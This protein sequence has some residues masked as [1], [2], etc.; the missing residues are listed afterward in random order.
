MLDLRKLKD[1]DLDPSQQQ[2][3][4]VWKL[5]PTKGEEKPGPIAHHTSVVVGDKMYLFGGSNLETEN[6]KF[7]SLE[8]NQFK[9]ETIK[10]RG[11][12]P[13]TRDEHTAVIFEGENSMIVYGGFIKGER[14]N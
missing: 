9:W 4:C 13:E 14:T 6:K 10:V 1:M 12:Q 7:F 2:R 3:D 8:M 5:V 11:D